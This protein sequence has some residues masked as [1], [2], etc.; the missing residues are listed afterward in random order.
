MRRAPALQRA[1]SA[2]GLWLAARGSLLPAAP[3]LLV[4]AAV[5]VGLFLGLDDFPLFDVDEGAFSEATREMLERGDFITTYLN[6]Q[7]R[8]DKPILTYW[9][10]ALSVSLFGV[11]EFA[12]RLPSALA[13]S[14]WVGAIL[15]FARRHADAGTGYAAALIAATTVGVCA[16]GRGATADALLNLL[17]ALAMFDIYR[18]QVQPLARYRYRVFLWMGLGLLTKGPVALVV[19]F[20]ASGAAFALH[21]QSRLW[22][23][24]VLDP[25]GWAILLA[26]A[27]PWYLA[28]YLREGNA[29]LAGF[30]MRHNVERFL[31]PLQGH[32]GTLFYY[33]PTILLLLLP[34]TGLFLRV[35]PRLRR[36]RATP[37]DTLLWCWFGFVFIFFSLAG[38]K[39]PHYLLYGVTPLFVLMAMHRHTLE[40]RLLAFLPPLLLLAFVVALPHALYWLGPGIGNAYVREALTR[41]GVFGGGWQLAAS[42][43]L[44]AVLA[45]AMA[46]GAVLWPKLAAAGL[47]CSV[48]VVTLLVPAVGAL[49]QGPV[50][51][52]A[53]LARSA[54]LAVRTWHFNVPS[55]SVYR[56]AVT[57][58]ATV[59]R[60]G[61]VLLTRSDE[62]PALGQVQVLYR[63]GGVVLAR[64]GG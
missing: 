24:A 48:A 6:G 11:G 27:G 26:V 37:L 50:R 31:S 40:S 60:P 53:L 10:Q 25:L 3:L 22:W 23:R 38:T 59:P 62:L 47:V 49:Q 58:R 8:F 15:L 18:Y 64:I 19:P 46:P 54:N 55:F 43:L 42:A 32:S 30:F 56:G 61:E 4:A 34:H 57:E 63:K 28:E 41:P 44:L 1:G 45:L 21:G 7:L 2:R 51:E 17:L 14:A 5:Y 12:F 52:A 36:W 33:A 29:F 16:I 20:A 13:A 39:L 35:L 9:L